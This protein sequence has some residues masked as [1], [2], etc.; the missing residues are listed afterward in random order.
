MEDIMKL[1]KS[2]KEVN[3]L[4]KVVSE[5]I[6]SAAKEKKLVFSGILAAILLGNLLK[7]KVV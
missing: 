4:I 2:L 3:L 5:T 1:V 7:S 6:V